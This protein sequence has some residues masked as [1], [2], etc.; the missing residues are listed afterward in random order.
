MMERKSPQTNVALGED[1]R[2]I[3]EEHALA[4]GVTVSETVRRLVWI[5]LATQDTGS[6]PTPEIAREI[7]IVNRA[8]AGK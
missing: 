1:L 2:A 8:F 3:V 7:V 4:N 5:G 6:V